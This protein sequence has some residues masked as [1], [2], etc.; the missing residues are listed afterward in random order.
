[1][2]FLQRASGLKWAALVGAA[3]MMAACA[4]NPADDASQYGVAA[5]GSP[6]DFAVNVGDRV[7]FETDSSELTSDRPGDARQAGALA[8]AICALYISPSKAMPTSA[9]RANII[10]RSAPE[11]PRRSRNIWP[12]AAS[13]RRACIRSAMARNG[14]SRCATTSPAGRR[15]AARSRCSAAINREAGLRAAPPIALCPNHG[16][17]S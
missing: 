10:S 4:K 14:R 12:P 6:Q 15:I 2:S 11:G 16:V 8:D 3:L 13:P 9:A 7:F 5:P 1:M 17:K